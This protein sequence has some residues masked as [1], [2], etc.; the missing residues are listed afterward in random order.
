MEEQRLRLLEKI[1]MRKIFGPKRPE[2]A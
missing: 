2:I 1:V